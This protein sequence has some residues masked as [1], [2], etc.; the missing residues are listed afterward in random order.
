MDDCLAKGCEVVVDLALEYIQSSP[1]NQQ[2]VKNAWVGALN[3]INARTNYPLYPQDPNLPGCVTEEQ[4]HEDDCSVVL[5]ILA[6]AAR[7]SSGQ[8]PINYHTVDSSIPT[9]LLSS[10]KYYCGVMIL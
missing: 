9:V 2:A 6:H 1:E 5:P 4:L 7:S 10:Q 3:F 8:K